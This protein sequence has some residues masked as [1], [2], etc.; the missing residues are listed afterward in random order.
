VKMLEI[1]K[2]KNTINKNREEWWGGD[3]YCGGN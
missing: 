1:R 3:Y 2:K